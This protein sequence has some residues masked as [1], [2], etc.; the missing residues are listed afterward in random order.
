LKEEKVPF[1]KIFVWE[2]DSQKQGLSQSAKISQFVLGLS[3]QVFVTLFNFTKSTYFD[4]NLFTPELMGFFEIGAL[5][6]K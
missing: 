1:L 2:R 4:N 5:I 3:S 6:I